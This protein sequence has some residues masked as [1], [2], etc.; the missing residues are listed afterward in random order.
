LRRLKT[1][2][3]IAKLIRL[4]IAMAL[5][6]ATAIISLTGWGMLNIFSDQ[7]IK[8]AENESVLI[9]LLLVDHNYDSLISQKNGG[10][11]V[12]QIEP[13]EIEKLNQ[14]FSE[15][16]T[17]LDIVKVKIFT[18]DSR[19]VYS[20]E[21]PLIGKFNHRNER[22]KR[23][24][25]GEIDSHIE[26]KEQVRDLSNELSLNV[27]VVETYIPI[28]VH[29][30]K[31]V[32]AFELYMDV[33]KFRD[34]IHRGALKSLLLLSTVFLFVYLF[35]FTI[36]RFGLKR[37]ANAEERLRQRA[38]IDWLTGILNRGELMSRVEKEFS[39]SER[40][41]EAGTNVTLGLAILDIDHFKEVN[42]SYG[43]QVGDGA[44]REVAVRIQ[45]QLRTY[46]I[47][48]RYGG[49]EFLILFPETSV[50]GVMNAAERIRSCIADKR[51]LILGQQLDVT[52]SIGI[53]LV[54]ADAKLTEAI[55][56]ADKAL[57]AAKNKGRNKIELQRQDQ[58][59]V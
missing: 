47:L 30:G 9:A 33:T 56:L 10:D 17:P 42:D 45:N 1:S 7:V 43:H 4:L 39:R 51:F 48:G 16:L 58:G 31:L 53:S 2:E 55:S 49:E 54:S 50:N 22:L 29:T 32:G 36:V 59:P 40:L 28:K 24:L 25:N 23:A 38:M 46:D 21:N 5:I 41:K 35:A 52:I 18:P 44:I 20:T 27:D 37:A 15:F 12:I 3:N 57:Y 19:V 13:F 11:A 6:S 34:E 26:K 8:M 14:S